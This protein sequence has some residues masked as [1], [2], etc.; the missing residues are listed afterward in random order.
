MK[1]SL[2]V[3]RRLKRA[4][5][6]VKARAPAVVKPSPHVLATI[7]AADLLIQDFRA[8]YVKLM[9]TFAMRESLD[10]LR[11]DLER[12]EGW[13]LYQSAL[14]RSPGIMSDLRAHWKPEDEV[15]VP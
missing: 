11:S 8:A 1:Q 4:K 9:F 12:T 7:E 2:R 15:R 14:A 10:P 6:A 3:Q 13:R 5:R